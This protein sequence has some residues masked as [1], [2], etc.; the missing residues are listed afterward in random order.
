MVGTRKVSQTIAEHEK[1]PVCGERY[2]G[3]AGLNPA[4][5]IRKL[6]GNGLEMIAR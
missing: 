1:R 4:R 6:E 5:I 2:S 3:K